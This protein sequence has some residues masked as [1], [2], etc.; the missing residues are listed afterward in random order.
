MRTLRAAAL[1]LL[2]LLA[3]PTLTPAQ[4]TLTQDEALKLAFPTA[5]AIELRTAFMGDQEVAAAKRLAG[6]GVEV[7][8]GVVTYYLA[9]RGSSPLG[10]AYFD[11]HRVR[12]LPEVV[13]IVV[14]PQATIERI[15]VLRFAEP[16]QYRAPEGWLEQFEGERLSS[17]LSLRGEIVNM[18][19]ASL[20]S[21]AVTDAA[22]RTLALHQ[23]IHST[24]AAAGR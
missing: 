24:P 13:M 3:F 10:T 17:E 14:S 9:K 19:G 2:L 6:S 15:E 18:T 23:V 5:T 1:A 22:R 20:T 8:S 7:K 16:P 12:T 21:K 11:A 4:S